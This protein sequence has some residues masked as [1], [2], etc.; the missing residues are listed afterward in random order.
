ME[1]TVTRKNIERCAKIFD[2]DIISI[3]PDNRLLKK[4]YR[5]MILNPE[6]KDYTRS[7]CR[8]CQ[9]LIKSA[10][11]N[12]AADKHIPLVLSAYSPD[13]CRGA[14]MPREELIHD[15]I[16]KILRSKYFSQKDR[17]YFWDPKRYN[18][19]PRFMHPLIF[20][21]YPKTKDIIKILDRIG[22]NSKKKFNPLSTNCHIMW[23]LIYLDIYFNDHNVYIKY[24]CNQIRLK[25]TSRIKYFF[26][27]PIGYWFLKHRLFKRREINKA[28]KYI[29]LTLDDIINNQT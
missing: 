18:Y 8:V 28:L 27:L 10:G 26:L 25:K 22:L 3:K 9:T 2:N 20:M 11:L 1:P 16:P 13:Q 19:I 29:D 6:N 12:I 7:V 14:E 17:S 24:L 21:N 4:I 5:H 15:W 23:L